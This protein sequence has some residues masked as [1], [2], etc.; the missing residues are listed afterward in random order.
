M[1]KPKTSDFIE[2]NGVFNSRVYDRVSEMYNDWLE[3]SKRP[4]YD[5][6]L[7]N[8]KMQWRR[9]WGIRETVKSIKTF[10]QMY[11]NKRFMELAVPMELPEFTLIILGRCGYRITE[12]NNGNLTYCMYLFEW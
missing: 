4:N 12:K 2:P 9:T 10:K 7:K 6:I 3:R 5:K 1:E 8:N 11:P